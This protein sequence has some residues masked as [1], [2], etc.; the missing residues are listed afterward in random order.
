M[1][2]TLETTISTVSSARSISKQGL[3]SRIRFYS[4]S[5]P[6][7]TQY[8]VTRQRRGRKKENRRETNRAFS[9]R[10]HVRHVG[11]CGSIQAPTFRQA[12][13]RWSTLIDFVRYARIRIAGCRCLRCSG[14]IKMGQSAFTSGFWYGLKNGADATTSYLSTFL[15]KLYR[16]KIQHRP[17]ERSWLFYYQP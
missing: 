10:F 13:R 1:Q 5:P 8:C 2:S 9:F 7:D 6:R 16:T 17:N 15:A 3:S 12:S 11:Y 4:F 14:V